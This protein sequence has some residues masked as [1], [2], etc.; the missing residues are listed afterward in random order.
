MYF[1][2]FSCLCIGINRPGKLAA[3]CNR[4]STRR[5]NISH[6]FSVGKYF[7][8]LGSPHLTPGLFNTLG[9]CRKLL[10][11][12]MK[13]LSDNLLTP[14]KDLFNTFHSLKIEQV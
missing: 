12:L 6:D 1:H 13:N 14:F 3:D 11:F 4:C 7:V 5:E 2:V 8:N 10:Q 9:E